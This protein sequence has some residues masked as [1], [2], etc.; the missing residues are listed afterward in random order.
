MYTMS[1]NVSPSTIS[2]T[3]SVLTDST[4]VTESINSPTPTA[5]NTANGE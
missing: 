3:L 5:M 1:S 4:S 2:S